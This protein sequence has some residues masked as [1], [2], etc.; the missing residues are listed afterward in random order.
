MT[1]QALT[2]GSELHTILGVNWAVESVLPAPEHHLQ[3]NLIK[4][5]NSFLLGAP[6]GAQT[7]KQIKHFKW[8]ETNVG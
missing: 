8:D 4:E 1:R 7:G 2:T 6:V 5:A 3:I